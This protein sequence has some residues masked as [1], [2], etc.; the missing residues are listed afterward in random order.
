MG[1]VSRDLHVT[2]QYTREEARR[3]WKPWLWIPGD[4]L[5]QTRESGD[6]EHWVRSEGNSEGGK[7][8]RKRVEK[9]FLVPDRAQ[10]RTT[11]QIAVSIRQVTEHNHQK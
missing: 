4:P 11:R 8:W 3:T 10:W 7:S 6:E 2:R 1:Y 5:I 9:P